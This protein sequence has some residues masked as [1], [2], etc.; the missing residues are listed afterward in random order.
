MSSTEEA[1]ELEVAG[2]AAP[3][4]TCTTR[5]AARAGGQANSVNNP[6]PKKVP[7]P[8]SKSKKTSSCPTVACLSIAFE[9]MQERTDHEIRDMCSDITRVNSSLNS[10]ESKFDRFLS[11]ME[12][13]TPKTGCRGRGASSN[14]PNYNSS[15][16]CSSESDIEVVHGNSPKAQASSSS[17]KSHILLPSPTQ[18]VREQ[19]RDGHIDRQIAREEYSAGPGNGGPGSPKSD[20]GFMKPY[21]YLDREGI[22]T[23]HQKLDI[24]ATMTY[25]EYVSCLLP[26][27]HDT[28][29][30]CSSECDDIIRHF[31]AVAVHAIVHPWPS[32]RTWTQLIWDHVEKGTCKWSSYTF[33]QNKRIR[34]SY[35]NMSQQSSTA[36]MHINP[37]TLT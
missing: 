15:Q 1:N 7:K 32:V 10:F 30:F 12:N 3:V 21:M 4:E 20:N 35:M 6:L 28:T 37:Q 5:S 11:A 27:I 26:L 24:R 23:V 22:Q 17:A 36:R 14:K 8:K 9:D 29:A 33:I 34:V 13:G 31:H 25:H 18:M 19:N 2:A 16:G